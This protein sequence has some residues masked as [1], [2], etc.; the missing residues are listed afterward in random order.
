M[1]LDNVKPG[2]GG[3]ISSIGGQ[4]LLRRRLLDMGLTPNTRVTVRKVAPMGDPIE[5]SLRSYILTIRKD[6]AAKIELKEVFDL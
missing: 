2:Q 3:I 1:T 4:G 5:L 6:E